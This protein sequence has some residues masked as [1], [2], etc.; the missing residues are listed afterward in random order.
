MQPFRG[1]GDM[2]LSVSFEKTTYAPIPHKFEAGTPAIAEVIGLGAA[3]DYLNAIGIGQ[4]KAHEDELLRYATDR[5]GA[6][7]G[8]RLIGTAKQKAAVLSFELDGIHPHDVGTLLNEEGVAVRTG[9]HCAQPVMQRFGVPATV[10]ASFA[11]YNT[12]T[13]VDALVA[14]IRKVQK[15]FAA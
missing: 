5:V 12:L 9:H 14:A 2:I 4:I 11:F 15:V 1:G 10:R 3:I 8:V 13:E 6:I 7:S